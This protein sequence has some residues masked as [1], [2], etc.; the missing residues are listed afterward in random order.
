V[1]NLEGFNGDVEIEAAFSSGFIDLLADVLVGACT[2]HL[3]KLVVLVG[4]ERRERGLRAR[5]AVC[6]HS[7]GSWLKRVKKG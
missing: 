2:D 4:G 6:F 5:F 1:Q 7:V 3:R